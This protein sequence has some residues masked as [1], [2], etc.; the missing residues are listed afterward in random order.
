[1]PEQNK[2]SLGFGFFSTV[3]D[4]DSWR[5]FAYDGLEDTKGQSNERAC[6]IDERSVGSKVT[7][8]EKLRS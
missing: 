1:M 6:Y 2:L 5:T 4:E 7:N 3:E 8:K